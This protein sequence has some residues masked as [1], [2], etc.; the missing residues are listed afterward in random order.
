MFTGFCGALRSRRKTVRQ[1]LACRAFNGDC[2]TFNVRETLRSAMDVP[3]G[4]LADIAI[5]MLWG[6]V[7]ERANQAAFQNREETFDCVCVCIPA[8]VLAGRMI[9]RLMRSELTANTAIRA[10]VVGHDVCGRAN[11]IRHDGFQSLAVHAGDMETA[12]G[13]IAL[14]ESDN[15]LFRLTVDVTEFLDLFLTRFRADGIT[16]VRLI[17]FDRAATFTHRACVLTGHRFT[18]TMEHKPSGFVGNADGALQLQSAHSLFGGTHKMIRQHPFMQG[19]LRAFKNGSDCHGELGAAVTA[20]PNAG[21]MRGRLGARIAFRTA[22]VRAHRTVRPD[23][24]LKEVA[25]GFVVIKLG[26]GK[27]CVSHD[28]SPVSESCA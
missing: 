19:N 22:A 14:N 9:D 16:P 5:Q 10:I 4:E 28:S 3:K 25:G 12:H 2:S 26:L 6:N 13:S 8:N 7:M 1:P 11:V 24:C 20:V 15:F 23:D 18:Q 27:Q 17:N 21:A